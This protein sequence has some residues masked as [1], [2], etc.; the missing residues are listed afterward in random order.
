MKSQDL[1]VDVKGSY[2]EHHSPDE[3]QPQKV[4]KIEESKKVQ[5]VSLNEKSMPQ[6]SIEIFKNTSKKSINSNCS[7]FNLSSYFPKMSMTG[8]RTIIPEL[9]LLI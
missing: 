9:T 4:L 1:R 7:V 8:F 3:E 6:E 2:H 5:E